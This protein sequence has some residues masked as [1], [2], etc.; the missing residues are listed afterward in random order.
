MSLVP[1]GASVGDGTFG[2][3]FGPKV[4][5]R[6]AEIGGLVPQGISAE[7]IADKWN[8]SR[9]DLDAFGALSQQRA[10]QATKE[11]RFDNEIVKVT[12]KRLDK[13]TKKVIESSDLVGADEGIRPG[14]T[15]ETLA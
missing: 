14:T 8:L 15:T 6:Y 11:G 7:M 13:E 1:M 9:E 10:E 5:L 2:F 4:G 12:E 3:P